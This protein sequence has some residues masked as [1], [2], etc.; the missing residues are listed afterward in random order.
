M[1]TKPESEKARNGYDYGAFS[2]GKP[3]AAL[4]PFKS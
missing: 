2:G 3:T 4:D 1:C